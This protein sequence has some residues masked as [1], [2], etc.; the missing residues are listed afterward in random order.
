M[1]SIEDLKKEYKQL[2][3]RAD[4]RLVRLEKLSQEPGFEAVTKYAYAK[5][6]R[7]IKHWSGEEG[8]RFNRNMPKRIRSIEAAIQDMKQFLDAPTSAK[9][10]I[11][12]TY[13][14]KAD[15]I[16]E[17]YGTNFTWQ[18]L[19]NYYNSGLADKLNSE[20]GSKTALIV[21]GV[22]QKQEKDVVDAIRKSKDVIEVV[23]DDIVNEAIHKAL[24]NNKIRGQIKR[25]S[26]KSTK[27]T[28]PV[29][30]KDT[31]TAKK[32]KTRK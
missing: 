18:D 13:K 12:K 2:A 5:A 14:Q 28:K 21:M 24:R 20:Y 11:I 32:K 16:N 10:G 4:Q 25:A 27:R 15:T 23:D 1:S 26:S 31:K 8:K 6:M 22:I 30:K 17:K 29:K 9:T 19:A 7:D 3:K